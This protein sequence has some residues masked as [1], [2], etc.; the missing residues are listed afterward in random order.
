MLRAASLRLAVA[1]LGFAVP[2]AA[3]AADWWV[4]VQRDDDGASNLGETSELRRTGDRVRL[5][6]HRFYREPIEGMKSARIEFE[7]DCPRAL[8]RERRFTDYDIRRQVIATGDN[9]HEQGWFEAVPDTVGAAIVIFACATPEERGARFRRLDPGADPWDVG[10]FYS[11]R[12]PVIAAAV[13]RTA[14]AK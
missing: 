5:W 1:L 2:A 4:I 6:T 11:A 12:S 3:E 10:E 14:A 7:I 13:P 8:W 9:T